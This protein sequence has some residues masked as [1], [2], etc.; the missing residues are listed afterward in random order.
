MTWAAI[1]QAAREAGDLETL[2]AV[3]AMLIASATWSAT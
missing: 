2:R 3:G 1:I